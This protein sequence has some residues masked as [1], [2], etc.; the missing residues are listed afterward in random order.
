MFRFKQFTVDD[1]RCSMKVGTDGVL[2]GAWAGICGMSSEECGRS[3]GEDIKRI[4]ILD[5]GTG[6]GLVALMLAQRYQQAEIV[7]I[8]ID[9]DATEQARENFR[10]SPWSSRLRA[11]CCRVQ[12]YATN[13]AG[14]Y[15]LIVSNPPF[16]NNSLKNPDLKR[17]MARHTDTL[18]MSELVECSSI[19]LQNGGELCVILPAWEEESIMA[20]TEKRGLSLRRVMR[21]QGRVDKPVKRLLLSFQ[22]ST[23]KQI[24]AE[25]SLVL[26]EGVNS[27]TEAYSLLTKDYYL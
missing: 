16:F 17:S 11:E 7:G 9:N 4:R 26:E 5:V 1:S 2:L 22:K 23:E 18:S 25:E 21:V 12:Q 3:V 8:D 14:K 13:N 10:G 19:M 15:R 27:R 20:E 24:V 6:S